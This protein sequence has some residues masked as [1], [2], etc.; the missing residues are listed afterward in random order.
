MFGR[1]WWR[2][3][4]VAV[5]VVF[6]AAS[7]RAKASAAELCAAAGQAAARA[8]GLP[9]NMLLAIGVVES[10][11]ADPAIGRAMPWPW[12]VN[13]DGAGA[14]FDTEAEAAAFARLAQSSGAVDVDVGCFQVSLRYHP[15]A[16]ASLD[17]ALDPAANAAFAAGFLNSL[18]QQTGSWG[19]AIAAYHSAAPEL[20]LPYRRLV[21]AA[22]RE[23]GPRMPGL[24]LDAAAFDAAAPDPSDP[25]DLVVIKLAPAARLVRVF[26]MDDAPGGG[27]SP[28]LPRVITP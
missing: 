16:F 10:G 27:L 3:I 19:A 8:A 12:T 13:V 4:I 1:G 28:R 14:F 11:R 7:V 2:G 23:L 24:A 17:Q 18:K 22:W 26:T 9:E 6:S 21:L 20:G 25:S 15:G 5:L